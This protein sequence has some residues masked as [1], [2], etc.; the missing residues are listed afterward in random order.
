MKKRTAR[1]LL[2]RWIG[3]P[4]IFLFLMMNVVAY[5]HAYKFTHFESANTSKTERPE[6]LSLT[7]KIRTLIF[8]INHPK[9][10]HRSLPNTKYRTVVLE[11]HESIECWEIYRLNA[12][13]T[14]IIFH[15]YSSE[16]SSMLDK[17][18]AFLDMGYSVLLVDFMGCGGSG[19]NQTTIGYKEAEDVKACVNYLVSREENNIIL[20]GTSMGAVAIMK[21]LSDHEL[22]VSSIILECPFGTMLETV[23]SRFRNIG[24]PSFPMAHLLMFWGG[25][26]NGFNAFAHNPTDYARNIEV[27]TLLLYGAQDI[28]VSREEIDNIRSN[29]PGESYLKVYPE[30]GH[31]NFLIKYQEDWLTDVEDFLQPSF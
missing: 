9:P 8:G 28:K 1:R 22:P 14:V 10:R 21:A 3:L 27:P 5:F 29:L 15:G 6:D 24:L 18:E 30:A 16:K 11:S 2:V 17:A 19:G 26:Q 13:G 4:F 7:E 25:I 12:K 31:E 23:Q 20:F